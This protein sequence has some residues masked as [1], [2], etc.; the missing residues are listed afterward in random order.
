M[1]FVPVL[2]LLSFATPAVA[3]EA[4]GNAPAAA[5]DKAK[6]DKNDPNK[7]VCR[8]V[9]GTGSLIVGRTECHT[10]AEWQQASREARET[11]NGRGG[12]VPNMPKPGGGN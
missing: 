4:S 10:R 8:S 3:Q 5:S 6:K 12:T 2:A 7:V 9:G 1:L 11:L